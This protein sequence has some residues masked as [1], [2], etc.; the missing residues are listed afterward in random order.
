MLEYAQ[1]LPTR[2]AWIETAIARTTGHKTAAMVRR[3]IR[4][5]ELMRS[6]ITACLGL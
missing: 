2:G 6:N 5:G 4:D 3:Y 1:S